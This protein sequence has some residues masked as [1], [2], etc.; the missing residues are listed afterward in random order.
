VRVDGVL[1]VVGDLLQRE[2]S[3]LLVLPQTHVYLVGEGKAKENGRKASLIRVRLT[4]GVSM[5]QISHLSLF[6]ISKETIS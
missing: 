4:W 5:R 3:P 1:K 6:T 2:T